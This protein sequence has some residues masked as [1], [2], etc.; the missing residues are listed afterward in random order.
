MAQDCQRWLAEFLFPTSCTLCG[1]RAHRDVCA[2]CRDDLPWLA[3]LCSR[4]GR[5]LADACSSNAVCG[6]CIVRPPAFDHAFVAFRYDYPIADL[7]RALKYRRR[8]F[9]A[10]SLGQL[11]SEYV[12]SRH[13]MLPDLLI[14]VPL[15]RE[16]EAERGFNQAREIA[17]VIAADLH[18]PVLNAAVRRTRATPAQAGL[19]VRKRR[20]N[21][22]HAFQLHGPVSC[23]HVAIIDD[24]ITTGSTVSE[25]T[26]VIRK[27]GVARV[28][29]W[30]VARAGLSGN[31]VL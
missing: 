25:L 6:A 23:R 2:D 21:V 16:R 14:P 18:V 29:V 3:N 7:L 30:A 31:D 26:R 24:V 20:R 5:P 28:D 12:L 1:V 13:V 9:L 27:A 17:A 4:C 15:H 10:R 19:D 22:R 8:L 11:L